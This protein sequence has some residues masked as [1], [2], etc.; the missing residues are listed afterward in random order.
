V[1]NATW[2]VNSPA[3]VSEI[4]DGELV[5]MNLDSGNFFSS[6]G[7][8]TLIWGCIE[9]RLSAEAIVSAVVSAYEID[10]QT[11][12]THLQRFIESLR[13][14]K[15]VREGEASVDAQAA[16]T[17]PGARSPFVAPEMKVYS[18]MKDLL[19]L[20]PIHDVAPEGWPALPEDVKKAV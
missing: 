4:I 10:A 7:S 17:P 20:D 8:G 5:V 16:P 14:E 1:A 15:L 3:V 12:R 13:A 11:V 9:K 18:D 6:S 19:M 2:I